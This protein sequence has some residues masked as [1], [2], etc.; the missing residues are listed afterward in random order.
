MLIYKRFFFVFI[1]DFLDFFENIWDFRNYR[2]TLESELE[3]RLE[4]LKL[5]VDELEGFVGAMQV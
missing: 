2:W 3:T 4:W 1:G 5:K